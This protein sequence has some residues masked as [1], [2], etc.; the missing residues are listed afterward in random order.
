MHPWRIQ[1]SQQPEGDADE[2]L[3]SSAPDDSIGT[4]REVPDAE[5]AAPEQESAPEGQPPPPDDWR[6]FRADLIA[7]ERA[8]G[9]PGRRSSHWAHQIVK[10][11]EKG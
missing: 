4:P 7:S 6:R 3:S 1:S 2:A 5:T 9:E 8:A 10:K 11:P